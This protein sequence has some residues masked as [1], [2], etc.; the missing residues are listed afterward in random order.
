[1][2]T[3]YETNRLLLKIENER[4][5]Y[6][7]LKFYADNYELF[8]RFEPTR[9]KSFYTLSHQRNYLN[10]EYNE[11]IQK[12]LLRLWVYPKWEAKCIMGTISFSNIV[13]GSF[14]SAMFGYKFAKK[15]HGF[16]YA[17]EACMEGIRIMFEEYDL[18]RIEA[19]IMPS[20]LPSI[21]LINRLGFSY[22]GMERKSVEINHKW[23]DHLRYALLSSNQ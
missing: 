4:I 8:E 16:G 15:Y 11:I 12:R 22:E 18:H 6:S 7:V 19:K 14:K 17:S 10:M 9:S 13:N 2:I 23:E 1:M 21:A 3:T 20:N 5:C